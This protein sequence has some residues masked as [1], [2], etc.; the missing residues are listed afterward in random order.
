MYLTLHPTYFITNIYDSKLIFVHDKLT[1]L[2][3]QF[4][5]YQLLK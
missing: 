4:F 3:S 2:L 5:F 1:K